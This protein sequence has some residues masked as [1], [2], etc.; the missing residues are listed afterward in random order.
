MGKGKGKGVYLM[1]FYWRVILTVVCLG[2]VVIIHEYGHFLVARYL[3]VRVERFTIGF[4]PEIFGWTMGNTRY[5]VCLMPL[6]GMV[7]LAGE[8]MDEHTNSP[9]EFFSQPWYRRIAI[10]AAGPAMNYVVAFVLFAV[11]AYVWGVIQP[12]AQPVIGEV[13]AGFPAAAAHVQPGD[14]VLSMDGVSVRNWQDLADRIHEKSGKNVTLEVRRKE[15][16][17]P[18]E[19]FITPMTDPQR[20]VG[21]IGILPEIEKVKVGFWGSM[22]I[23]IK[24]IGAWTMQPINYLSKKIR[25]WEGPK[26]L[27]GPLGIAEMVSKA[28]REGLPYV[29]YLMAIISTGLGLFNIFPI[30]ILDGGHI[31]LYTIEGIIRR[32]L[33]RRMMALANTIGLSILLT[34]FI[35]ASYQDV[36]RLRLGLWR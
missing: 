26:E 15:S 12:S 33:S 9:D 32:P 23:S 14:R 22:G 31:M 21:V 7:R 2:L 25:R 1:E 17:G 29:I 4:G 35:Y 18:L 34:L 8:Y 16:A 3:G 19:I 36:L 13:L 10:A 11:S 6:G 5:A 27:S 28:T 30:P 24:D 20:N